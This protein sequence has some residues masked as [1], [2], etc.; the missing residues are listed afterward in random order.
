MD[1]TTNVIALVWVAMFV[2]II[3]LG[4]FFRVREIAAVR[5]LII[6]AGVTA[7]VMTGVLHWASHL[8]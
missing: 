1:A 4:L 8:P 2:G 7:S 5:Y 6:M 3:V